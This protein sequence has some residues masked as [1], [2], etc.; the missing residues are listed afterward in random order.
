MTSFIRKFLKI[1]IKMYLKMNK[2]A[3][4]HIV[5][6]IFRMYSLLKMPPLTLRM[7]STPVMKN[8]MR[9]SIDDVELRSPRATSVAGLSTMMP[10]S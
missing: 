7:T 10:L 5:T 8:P 6:L 3:K 1:Y 2:M 9:V 4:T